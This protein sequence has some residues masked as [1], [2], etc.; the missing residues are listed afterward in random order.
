LRFSKRDLM[1]K[2]ARTGRRTGSGPSQT[3]QQA[4]YQIILIICRQSASA[5]SLPGSISLVTRRGPLTVPACPAALPLLLAPILAARRRGPSSRVG[6]TRW[7]PRLLARSLSL[8]RGDR[9]AFEACVLVV[10]RE[11]LAGY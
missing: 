8:W 4:S 5:L 11:K 10:S 9:S 6:R 2:A 7:M 3:P 1:K